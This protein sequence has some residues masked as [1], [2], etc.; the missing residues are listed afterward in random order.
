[1]LENTKYFKIQMNYCVFRISISQVFSMIGYYFGLCTIFDSFNG[2]CFICLGNISNIC[3]SL[4]GFVSKFTSIFA[5]FCFDNISCSTLHS[6][7]YRAE[8]FKHAIINWCENMNSSLSNI[9]N[10]IVVLVSLDLLPCFWSADLISDFSSNRL[11][12]LN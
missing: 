1:M 8:S 11:S 7:S 6:S 2:F 4:K 10:I 3:S 9:L 12:T 5:V